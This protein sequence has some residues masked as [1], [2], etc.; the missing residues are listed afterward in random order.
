MTIQKLHKILS[1]LIDQGHGR[2]TI[3]VNKPSLWD[4]N[5]T[6]ELCEITDTDYRWYPIVDGDGFSIE[7]KDGMEHG[8]HALILIGSNSE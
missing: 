4:G 8:K 5:E 3:L 7:N 2:K 6:F 1:E